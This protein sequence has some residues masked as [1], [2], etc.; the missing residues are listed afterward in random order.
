MTLLKPKGLV[1]E[2]LPNVA[3]LE[4]GAVLDTEKDSSYRGWRFWV[5]FIPLG[6]ASVL[7]ALEG[8]ALST[9]LPSIINDLR[10][11]D[12]YVWFVNG[13]FISL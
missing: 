7:V 9:A 2:S 5:I 8:T 10:D 3:K 4:S 12:L 11:G 1:K 6:L 13:Y